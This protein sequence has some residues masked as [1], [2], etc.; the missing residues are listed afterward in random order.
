MSLS[1]SLFL[2]WAHCILGKFSAVLITF[3]YT[4]N[5]NFNI[6][7]HTYFLYK[8]KF[9]LDNEVKY[10]D[11]SW[12]LIGLLIHISILIKNALEY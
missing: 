6:V 1:Q 4:L 7:P 8:G 5:L 9:L 10:K 11:Q 3:R 2:I 12:K